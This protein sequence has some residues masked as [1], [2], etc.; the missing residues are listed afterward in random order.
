MCNSYNFT[1]R[2]V[3]DYFDVN[4]ELHFKKY[5][6]SVQRQDKLDGFNLSLVKVKS[7][8]TYNF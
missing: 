2:K 7:E 5:S 8:S 1:Q 3:G 6:V 4:K